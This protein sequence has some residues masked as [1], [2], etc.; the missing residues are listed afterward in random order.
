MYEY[1]K[2]VDRRDEHISYDNCSNTEWRRSSRSNCIVV[3]E[4]V[5]EVVVVETY[6]YITMVTV[7]SYSP[8]AFI[9]Y[10]VII[11]VVVVVVVIV[12]GVDESDEHIRYDNRSDTE[13]SK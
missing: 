10:I 2:D 3:V 9:I 1:L 5:V 11:I 8:F 6:F 4:V 13:W 7:Y 12:V